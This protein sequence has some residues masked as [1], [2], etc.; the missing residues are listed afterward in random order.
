MRRLQKALIYKSMLLT[1]FYKEYKTKQV[2][3]MALSACF[4]TIFAGRK[5]NGKDSFDR[6]RKKESNIHRT[7]CEYFSAKPGE[8]VHFV[9]MSER[10]YSV[11]IYKNQ[12]LDE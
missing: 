4:F 6:R 11:G 5:R 1:I 3:N 8:Y 7:M 2:D 12:E 9:E 10:Y